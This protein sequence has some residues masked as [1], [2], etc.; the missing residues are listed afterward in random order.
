[1]VIMG[2]K[3]NSSAN[4]IRCIDIREQELLSVV[5]DYYLGNNEEGY[6]EWY[7]KLETAPNGEIIFHAIFGHSNDANFKNKLEEW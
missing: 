2:K 1:M 3:K 7:A 4:E 6:D 5:C